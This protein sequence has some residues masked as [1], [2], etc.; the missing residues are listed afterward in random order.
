MK[1]KLLWIANIQS[2]NLYEVLCKVQTQY[3]SNHQEESKV[4]INLE[5]QIN[6][7]LCDTPAIL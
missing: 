4:Q 7:L 6:N 3:N 2:Y 1:F 5:I